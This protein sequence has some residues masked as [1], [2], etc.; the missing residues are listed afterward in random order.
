MYILYSLI[1]LISASVLDKLLIFI[2]L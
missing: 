1:Q 2:R